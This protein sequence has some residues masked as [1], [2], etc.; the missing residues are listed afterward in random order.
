MSTPREPSKLDDRIANR[1]RMR[2]QLELHRQDTKI[3]K[4]MLKVLFFTLFLIALTAVSVSDGVSV[5]P[6]INLSS[7]ASK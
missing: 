6:A 3:K 1:N 5:K 2:R 4:N 7:H